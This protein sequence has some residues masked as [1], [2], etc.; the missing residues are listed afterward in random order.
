MK[1]KKIISLTAAAV[2]LYSFNA[3]SAS[4]TLLSAGDLLETDIKTYIN[5]CRIKSYN[6]N[7]YTAIVAE[8]LANYGF[9]VVWDATSR[10]LAVTRSDKTEFSG[11]ILD[12]DTSVSVGKKSGTAYYTDIRTTVNGVTVLSYNIG[13]KTA[14]FTDSLKLYGNVKFDGNSRSVLCTID[15]LTYKKPM[16]TITD[17]AVTVNPTE[18]IDVNVPPVTVTDSSETYM[19]YSNGI[20]PDYG[21]VTGVVLKSKA[22]KSN[23]YISYTYDNYDEFAADK[24][25]TYLVDKAGFEFKKTS[26]EGEKVTY[27]YAK[28][29]IALGIEFD[30][31]S[32]TITLTCKK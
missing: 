5:G 17:P 28:S 32:K 26:T 16:V 3:F 8:D 9:N 31:S 21:V 20:V 12:E 11:E 7:G 24:Y 6:V 23:G 18:E 19:C 15:G 14:V 27:Y 2:M 10:A 4:P 1:I 22:D 29:N 13:G 25:I 30:N